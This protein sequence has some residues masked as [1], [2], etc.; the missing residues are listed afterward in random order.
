MTSCNLG[1]RTYIQTSNIES[2]TGQCLD[3][4][5]NRCALYVGFLTLFETRM[6]PFIIFPPMGFI[7]LPEL[8]NSVASTLTYD[9][10]NRILWIIAVESCGL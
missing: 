5:K 2:T 8:P 6:F 4:E 3:V 7:D 1:R 10:S 9:Y